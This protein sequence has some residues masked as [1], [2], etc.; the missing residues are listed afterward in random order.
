MSSD[1]SPFRIGSV[2]YLNAVPLTRGIESEILFATPARLAEMLRRDELDAALV[3][4]TEAL[5]N[6]RYDIL[7]GVAI[8]SLG[9]VYSVLLAHCVP[10]ESIN[11]VFCDPA[12]LTSVNLLKVLLA[13][14]GVK[15][16]FV[17]LTDY[18]TA[19]ERDAVLLIGDRAI[20]FQ[21]ATPVHEIFDL[22]TAWYELTKL[23][24]VYAV[25]ALRRGIENLELRRELRQAKQFGIETLEYII[26]TREEYDEDFR[27]DYLGWHVHYHLAAD[28]KRGIAKFCELLQK[29]G[30]G[31]VYEPKFVS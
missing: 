6:D 25:W 28:E 8:A 26:E 31:P 23:P 2:Q 21:R 29:Y 17:P 5:L 20:D 10:L 4:I 3:S 15:P 18:A 22:G 7:D 14:R 27:R 13:E 24:F 12:S 9:E 30:L 11:E 1:A 16:E 19:P